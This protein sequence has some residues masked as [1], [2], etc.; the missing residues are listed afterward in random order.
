MGPWGLA[1]I[2]DALWVSN[3]KSFQ[4]TSYSAVGNTGKPLGVSVNTIV[5]LPT[6]IVVNC[7][8]CFTISKG[9]KSAPARIIG[10]T[11]EV[12]YSPCFCVFR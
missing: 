12:L 6:G 11:Q 5:P 10:V 4:L 3:N 8:S 1:I 2:G 9:G 7:T